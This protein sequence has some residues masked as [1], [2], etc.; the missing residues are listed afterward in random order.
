MAQITKFL[1]SADDRKV[2]EEGGH[3]NPS[4]G[5]RWAAGGGE[6]HRKPWSV[7]ADQPCKGARGS[8]IW[9]QKRSSTKKMRLTQASILKGGGALDKAQPGVAGL[10][11]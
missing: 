7:I 11:F 6:V 4:G 10:G 2:E 3:I 5:R 9:G 1:R 8:P